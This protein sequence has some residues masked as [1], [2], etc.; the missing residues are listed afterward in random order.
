MQKYK[1]LSHYSQIN[2]VQFVSF[3]T[4]DSLDAFLNK[5]LYSSNLEISEQQWQIDQ[6][7]DQSLKGAYFYTDMIGVFSDYIKE[8]EPEFYDLI[9]FSIMPNHLH[10]L[11]T[12]K[13]DL[14][15]IMQKLKGG[16][17]RL[18]NQALGKKGRFWAKDY[19]DKAIRDERHF[20][21]TYRYIKNNAIKAGLQDANRRFYGIYR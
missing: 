1:H 21:N 12:Q 11:F 5:L 10:I 3:R 9:A 18:L 19:Y 4:H 20:Y 16:S 8:L 7:L 14:D 13:Q 15:V 17:S 6:Y 2:A